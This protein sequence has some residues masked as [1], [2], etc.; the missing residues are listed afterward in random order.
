M[1]A[2]VGF[3]SVLQYEAKK[4]AGKNVSEIIYFVSS[5]T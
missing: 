1:F 2:F 5:R 4:L 3:D